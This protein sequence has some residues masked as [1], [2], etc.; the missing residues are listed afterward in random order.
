[1][2]Y[3]DGQYEP[4]LI[5]RLFTPI[6]EGRADFVLGSRFL[7]PGGPLI[8]GMPRWKYLADRGLTT[9]DNRLLGTRFTELQTGYRAYSRRLLV[10]VPWLRN[11]LDR[12]FD[13]EL[14]L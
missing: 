13:S 10:D 9:I 4:L 2:L 7:S 14:L 12:S 3:P 8:D 6:L 5:P 11:S 1:M